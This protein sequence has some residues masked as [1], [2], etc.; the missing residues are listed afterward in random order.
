MNK[1]EAVEQFVSRSFNNIPLSLLE[2]AYGNELLEKVIMPIE[3]KLEDF[4]LESEDEPEFYEDEPQ[5]ETFNSIGEYN[6]A[7]E[8][9]NQA[10]EEYD[11]N[12]RKWQEYQDAYREYESK[13]EDYYPMWG[14]IFECEDNWLGEEILNNI[15]SVQNIGFI[16]M[17]DFDELNVCLGVAGAGYSFY[18]AHWTPLYDLLGLQWHDKE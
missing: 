13:C 8:Q 17:D 6:Q 9:F 11:D 3:P 2:R 12:M 1:K 15:E 18:D 14:T 5:I 16:V 10:K 4:E 7:V